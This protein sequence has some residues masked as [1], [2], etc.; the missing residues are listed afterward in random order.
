V[1]LA[2]ADP[3]FWR[4]QKKTLLN[5]VPCC[6]WMWH[7]LPELTPIAKPIVFNFFACWKGT[8]QKN[9]RVSC[10]I[11]LFCRLPVTVYAG[12]KRLGI[13]RKVLQA[14]FGYTA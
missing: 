4:N 7:A 13:A 1:G 8:G 2:G 10:V 11:P 3:F 5:R 6:R 12:P 9:S 14:Y